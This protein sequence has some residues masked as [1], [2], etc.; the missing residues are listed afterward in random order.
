MRIMTFM[1]ENNLMTKYQSGFRKHYQTTDNLFILD[2]LMQYYK[3]NKK[4]LYLCFIDLHKAFDKVWRK[5]LFYK[6]CQLG[7]GGK[8]FQ[9]I[10]NMYTDNLSAV[11]FNNEQLTMQ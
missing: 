7:I 1:T 3:H 6:L 4:G 9:L 8:I 2:Q 11:K 10:K 5:G